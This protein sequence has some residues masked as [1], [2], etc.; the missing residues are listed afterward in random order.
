MKF[1]YTLLVVSL[2]AVSSLSAQ[3]DE[4]EFHEDISLETALIFPLPFGAF[5]EEEGGLGIN[6]QA[7]IGTEFDFKW[8][9]VWPD[10]FENSLTGGIAYADTIQFFLDETVWVFNND[11]VG[12]PDGLSF[13]ITPEDGTALPDSDA[14]VACIRLSGTPSSD[15]IPGDYFMTF[16][17]RTCLNAPSVM[18]DGCTDA[19]IPGI[20]AGFPGEY[21]LTVKAEGTTSVK[22]TLNSN[23][24][25]RVSPNPFDAETVIEFNSEGLSKDYSFE[26][27]DLNGSLIRSRSLNLKSRQQKIVFDAS[28]LAEGVYIFQIKGK[29]G[30]ITDRLV[31]QR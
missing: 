19:F 7:V 25:L 29:E 23:V 14:P 15:V 1:F 18:F 27:F 24:N 8:T 3:S 12:I 2:F 5:T 16:S 6:K 28:N 21:K 17:V 4:C 26:V 20:I 10:S 31:V 9:M 13:S 30:I 22:E 11:T